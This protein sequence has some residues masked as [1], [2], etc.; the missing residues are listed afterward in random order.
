MIRPPLDR[1][2]WCSVPGTTIG[3]A[4]TGLNDPE[5]TTAMTA[6]GE[7]FRCSLATPCA[8][9]QAIDFP[10]NSNPLVHNGDSRVTEITEN[11]HNACVTHCIVTC[12]WACSWK[13]ESNAAFRATNT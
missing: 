8:S 5:V 12:C 1:L 9:S 13:H 2:G 4:L 3:G 11:S 7:G 6:N 10:G